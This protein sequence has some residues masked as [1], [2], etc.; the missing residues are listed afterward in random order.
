MTGKPPGPQPEI[1]DLKGVTLIRGLIVAALVIAA[2][3]AGAATA[4]ADVYYKNCTAARE[5][6]VAPILQGEDGYA[7]HLD[8][9]GD[10]IAC[11]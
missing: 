8:R 10:G 11:E 9:D 4:S 2:T 6:G 1:Q 7:A 3:A 5:A